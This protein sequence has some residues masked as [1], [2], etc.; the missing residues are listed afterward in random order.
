MLRPWPL[1]AALLLVP[2]CNCGEEAK[3]EDSAADAAVAAAKSVPVD[4]SVLGAVESLGDEGALVVVLRPG[5]WAGL[6]GALA[7]WLARLPAEAEPLRAAKTGADLPDLL[8]YPM[9]MAAG[10]LTLTGW[11]PSRPIVASLGEVPYRGVPGTVTPSLPV[12]DGKVSSIRHQV[13]VPATDPAA[14]IGALAGVL[15]R[16][17]GKAQPELV[18]GRQGARAVRIEQMSVA[19]L[20]AEAAV[21]VVVFD[22]GVM[23][24]AE[25]LAAM[26][27][28]LDPTPASPVATPALSLLGQ[29]EAVAAAWVRPWRMRPL[30]AV[31]GSVQMLR[32][33]ATVSSDHRSQLLARGT[34]I[35][36]ASELLMTD[37]GAEI[38]DVAMALVVDDGTVRLRSAMSLTPEGE[39]IFEA[40]AKGAG[41]V[42]AT[43]STDA[44][45][46]V[47]MRADV[48]AMLDATEPPP[49]L[50]G[51]SR[52]GEIAEAIMEGGFFATMYIGLRHPLGMLRMLEGF[53]AKEDLPLPID[54]L[55]VA[56]HLVWRGQSEQG[57]KV[58]LALHWPKDYVDRPL[59]AMVPLA[60][61]ERGFESLRLDT[62]KHQGKPV[63][64][65]GLGGESASTFDAEKTLS[66]DAF[67]QAKVSFS[68]LGS[69][70]AR[71]EDV[72]ALLAGS[73]E[74]V[75]TW[76]HRGRALLAEVAWSPN[77][78]E[79]VAKPVPVD[80]GAGWT[81]PLGSTPGGKG[82]ACLVDAGRSLSAGL[83]ATVSVSEDALAA[84]F[85]KGMAEAE[86]S[87]ACAEKD[88][89][90]AEAAAK[91]RA[92]IVRLGSDALMSAHQGDAAVTLLEQQCTRSKN[93]EICARHTAV[94]ALP[95][96]GL[97]TVELPADCST[98]YGVGG[99]DIDVRV[100]AKGISLNG[101]IVAVTDVPA[102]LKA[103]LDASE[104]SAEIMGQ[105]MVEERP[106]EGVDEGRR[107]SVGLAIDE[108]VDMAQVR[109]LL[110]AMSEQKVTRVVVSTKA[111]LRG[112]QPISIRLATRPPETSGGTKPAPTPSPTELPKKEGVYG[113]KGPMK[114][115]EHSGILGALGESPMGETGSLMGGWAVLE[116]GPGTVTSRSSLQP[117]PQLHTA[118]SLSTLRDATD[119]AFTV[120]V[121][122]A[123]GVAW[124][125]VARTLGAACDRAMLVVD[126][127][128]P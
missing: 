56:A 102:R 116:V 108:S 113:I 96:P 40:A 46:D 105:M 18:E 62:T 76:E 22:E 25:R 98:P 4:P 120:Y 91:M 24:E 34:Q 3:P 14:L 67:M 20:P 74:I 78:G 60:K 49:A 31:A 30:A 7:S 8:A 27:E 69:E 83:S 58:A 72:G 85:A 13:L 41:D 51:A 125:D 17:G 1:L 86:V 89:A 63:T 110:Q 36:L 52:P 38:D 48:R 92:M 26:R 100:D 19:M 32:A 99:G 43:A 95:R 54:T 79:V 12:L 127:P 42:L 111:D 21:R 117:E 109:P 37:A 35:V 6:H 10:S 16:S 81:S 44:W 45:V 121:H 59:A 39:A 65:F 84:I 29:P 97:P 106:I 11:D 123:D 115:P 101:A 53:A 87:L 93:P 77:G 64:V 9:G 23:P 82:A 68:R 114:A 126:V 88:E 33:V 119:G 47:S 107:A 73:G 2:A 103:A 61:G 124:K 5:Q 94:A 57:P 104:A 112:H 128:R 66:G 28:R 122:G 15:E 50:A 55:P 70:F 75:T 118:P 90:T 71:D 80:Q